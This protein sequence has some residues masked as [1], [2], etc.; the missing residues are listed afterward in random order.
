MYEFIRGKIVELN[1]A[2]II[3]EAGGIGYFVNISLNTFSKLKNKKEGLVLLHQ[4]VREDAHILYGFSE[5]GEPKHIIVK[6]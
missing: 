6:L 2:N 1:P 3:I 5:K 4:V